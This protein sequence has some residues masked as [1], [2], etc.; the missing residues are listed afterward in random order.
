MP[1]SHRILTLHVESSNFERGSIVPPAAQ[2]KIDVGIGDTRSLSRYNLGPSASV[3]LI[4]CGV[5]SGGLCGHQKR[6]RSRTHR[7]RSRRGEATPD[8]PEP[9][10]LLLHVTRDGC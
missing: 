10:L 9:V 7:E 6:A 1:Q 5:L 4:F 2:V 3:P 8:L